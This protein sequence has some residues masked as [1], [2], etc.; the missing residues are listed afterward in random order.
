MTEQTELQ[1]FEVEE[2][3]EEQQQDNYA[4][5]EDFF[6]LPERKYT[7]YYD[8]D[9]DKV[10][11]LRSFTPTEQ[12]E[13]EEKQAQS[14]KRTDREI[15]HRTKEWALTRSICNPETG[16]PIFNPD[17]DL[18]LHNELP[19]PVINRAFRRFVKLN[20][21]DEDEID[22]LVGNSRSAHSD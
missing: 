12:E 15:A 10:V 1:D 4:T 13:F 16:Q 19:A 8:P 21:F 9:L 11:G 6:N 2:E 3:Q 7:E 5:K 22:A 20:G 17:D 14:A 18:R